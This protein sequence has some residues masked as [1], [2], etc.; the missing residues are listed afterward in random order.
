MIDFAGDLAALMGDAQGLAIDAVYTPDGGTPV[1]VRVIRNAADEITD[2]G[3]SRIQSET[4]L[5]TVA[6]AAV[7]AP[8]AGDTFTIGAEVL[9]VQG[10]P[11][12]DA[13]RLRWLIEAVA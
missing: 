13:R 9:T 7:P 2:F 11:R 3:G 12:R 10:S 1:A 6:C 4:T 5:L 8:V